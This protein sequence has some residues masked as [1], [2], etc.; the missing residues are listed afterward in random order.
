MAQNAANIHIGA[1]RI[2]V[3]GVAPATG[4][5]PTLTAHTSGVPTSPQ[6]GFTEVG[7]TTGDTTSAYNPNIQKLMS[8]QAF[9]TI[10]T[11]ATDQSVTIEFEAQERVYAA[12]QTAFGGIGSV[13]DGSKQLFYFGGVF[14]VLS[15]CVII[16]SPRRDNP[17][18]FELFTL[19][20]A[21]NMT[22]IPLKWSRTTPSTYKI[23]LQGVFDTTR[24][25][26]DQL[27]QFFR[28]Y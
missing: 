3:G 25:V 21:Q 28:E 1:G 6:T 2:F 9:G 19:Y 14:A 12:L 27:G 11:Y 17:A 18:K 22:G 24:S 10:D 5:P 4:T 7:H 23:S 13:N 15:Q 8:E 16:S 26:G 20:K